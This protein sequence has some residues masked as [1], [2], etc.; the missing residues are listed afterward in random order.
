L[1]KPRLQVKISEI[2]TNNIKGYLGTLYHK[3]KDIILHEIIRPC[4]KWIVNDLGD[5]ATKLVKMCEED[6]K[7]NR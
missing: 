5:T 1:T 4:K 2:N 7:N 6:A 3:D